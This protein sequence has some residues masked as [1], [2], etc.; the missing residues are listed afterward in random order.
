MTGGHQR[1]E[2]R[3]TYRLQVRASFDLDAAANVADYLQALGVDWAYLSPLLQATA[4]SDHGYD[5]VDPTRVDDDR[6]GAKALARFAGA[7]RAHRLGVLVDIVPNHQ[8]VAVPAQNPWWWDVLLHGRGS[9]YA[10]AFDI[11]WEFGGGRV[12]LPVLGGELD[13]VIGR[14]EIEVTPAASGDDHGLARYFDLALPLAP[15]TAPLHATRDAAAV[16]DVLARQHWQ[17]A[18]WR[19][20]DAVLNYRRFFTVTSLAGVR[21]EE[22]AVFDASHVEV[23]R[24]VREGLVDGL[25]IDHPDGLA[26]PGGYLDRLAEQTGGVYTVVE[27]ILEPGE[28]LPGWWATDGT[29]GYDALA[30]IDRV[31]V[32]PAGEPV[33][34]ALDTRLRGES[35]EWA[36][37]IHRA[38]RS[39]ADGSQ[40]AEVGRLVRC[41][42]PE[43][44]DRLG[45]DAARD[46]LAEVLASFHVYRAYSPAGSDY[47]EHA[48][49]TASGH[50]P[51]LSEAIAALADPIL[52][53]DTEFSRRFMQTTG[54]VMAKGVEDQSFYR[55]TRLTSLTEV[56]AD[57]SLFTLWVHELHEAFARRQA[58]WPHALT[59]LTTHDTK[60]SEDVRARLAV[61]AEVP[62]Q[63]AETLAALRGIAS[64]GNGPL[65]NLLWQAIVGAWPGEGDFDAELPA[66]LG[67][68]LHGYAEKAAREGAVGTSWAD[69]NADFEGRVHAVV[70]AAVGAARGLVEKFV[71]VIVDAGR[72]NALSAKLLQLAGPG[73]PDVYQ[74]TELWDL[75]LVDP[76]NRRA[77]DFDGRRALLARLD[78]GWRPD[79]DDTGAAK[80]LLVSR[81][82]RLRRDRPELFSRYV[83]LPVVGTASDHALAFDRGGVIAVAARLPVGLAARGGWEHTDTAVILPAGLWHEELTGRAIHGGAAPLSDVLRDYPV[84]LLVRA[85]LQDG[86]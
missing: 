77:V 38:K 24:W 41:L 70:D 27:K 5:V 86:V 9:A 53:V 74:G 46:A 58:E 31:L 30:E 80:L 8:G 26:D 59:A 64:T 51:D 36:D 49:S 34:T 68:R 72:R 7:A 21:V 35:V 48:L 44:R 56:G 6:G 23:L 2:P 28:R 45:V 61:L 3:S 76:D 83:P 22:P 50:R 60:R 63:W 10:E 81:A 82:L 12:W 65:D 67:A 42:P 29:T 18:F 43:V 37:M 33:L 16:R 71:S 55:Y 1:R 54:P 57:P 4:G 11:D 79:I 78:D 73:V 47:V 14:G 62:E 39:V 75:S 19:E 85:Q 17:L 52:A 13:E 25:R 84:A 32:D 69:Q 40:A 20:D 66:D 15:G